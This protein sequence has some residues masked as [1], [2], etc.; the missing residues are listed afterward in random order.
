MQQQLSA[1]DQAYLSAS[2]P[3]LQRL[4]QEY[5]ALDCFDHSLWETWRSRIDLANFRREGDYLS[6]LDYGMTEQKYWATL[7]AVAAEDDQNYL[8]SFPEDGLFGVISFPIAGRV[9]TR[10]LLDSIL[11]INFLR[12][13]LPIA[14]ADR[15]RVLDVGAGYGRFAWRFT[16]AFPKSYVYCLD[17]VPESTFLCDFYIQ[18]RGLGDRARAVPLGQINQVP[19]PIDLAVNIH[20]WSE[21]TLKA[22]DFW[23]DHLVAREVKHLFVVPHTSDFFTRERDGSKLCFL[24]AIEAH[25]Y[26]LIQTRPKFSSPLMQEVGVYPV[27]YYL[28]Q[29]VQTA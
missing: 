12:A 3:Y 21:C 24:P 17:A 25:G 6:Q 8:S 4:I 20:S 23:L 18:F 11:E 7:G 10:D 22:V 2:N 14:A 28:F 13:H 27:T 5:Q 19:A 16:T 1:Q 29:R 26:R 15:L 9:I